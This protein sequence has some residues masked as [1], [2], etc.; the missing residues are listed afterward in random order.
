MAQGTGDTAD[1]AFVVLDFIAPMLSA[2]NEFI[3][4]L[5]ILRLAQRS[6]MVTRYGIGRL[7]QSRQLWSASPVQQQDGFFW[8]QHNCQPGY[9]IDPPAADD[10]QGSSGGDES[11]LQHA[12]RISSKAAQV[13]NS[14]RT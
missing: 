5:A 6:V 7:S 10:K 14:S 11:L 4:K 12:T 1:D 8:P 13:K 9:R 2:L 3:E